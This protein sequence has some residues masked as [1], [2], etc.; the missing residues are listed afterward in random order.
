MNQLS[1]IDDILLQI[2]SIINQID[3]LAMQVDSTILNVG[4]N[5]IKSVAILSEENA[6]KKES[7]IWFQSAEQSRINAQN[8][9]LKTTVAVGLPVIAVGIISSIYNNVSSTYKFEEELFKLNK[10]FSVYNKFTTEQIPKLEKLLIN[11]LDLINKSDFFNYTISSFSQSDIEFL[12]NLLSRTTRLII[13][14]SKIEA[15]RN[16]SLKID[17]ICK[18]IQNN[19][20]PANI[21]NQKS[22]FD[23]IKNF[24]V[25]TINDIIK[26]SKSDFK[27]ALS[28]FYS[29]TETSLNTSL[30]KYFF[31]DKS[32]KNWVKKGANILDMPLLVGKISILNNNY[33]LN[34]FSKKIISNIDKQIFDA[35]YEALD[36]AV[37]LEKD[38]LRLTLWSWSRYFNSLENSIKSLSNISILSFYLNEELNLIKNTFNSLEK[39]TT[40]SNNWSNYTNTFIKNIEKLPFI[41]ASQYI[42]YKIEKSNREILYNPSFAFLSLMVE[43]IILISDNEKLLEIIYTHELEDIYEKWKENLREIYS[44]IIISFL[45]KDKWNISETIV[46]L[47]KVIDQFYKTEY[48][49]YSNYLKVYLENNKENIEY[50]EKI[51]TSLFFGNYRSKNIYN[52]ILSNDNVPFHIKNIIEINNLN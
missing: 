19:N 38:G 8:Q 25:T 6:Y 3:Q 43:E 27:L 31:S 51:K 39:I 37:N 44:R 18:S 4:F 21:N 26:T 16:L 33:K 5:I 13:F 20:L 47:D 36:S 52:N 10:T 11:N 1:E 30:E 14:I 23:K 9:A 28:E 41:V 32:I 22:L 34:F 29:E 40:I 12:D 7:E 42:L 45:Y 35:Y 24:V 17:G 48:Q 46:F 15:F 2:E 49:E 50:A